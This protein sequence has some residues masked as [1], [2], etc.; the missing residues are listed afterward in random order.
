[1]NPQVNCCHN[2]MLACSNE[3]EYGKVV[4][5]RLLGDID[6]VADDGSIQDDLSAL[7]DERPPM[8]LFAE[9]MH[10]VLMEANRDGTLRVKNMLNRREF[11]KAQAIEASPEVLEQIRMDET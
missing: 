6:A 1:M 10:D 11:C 7:V 9:Q 8:N 3:H 4:R 5:Q 2:L